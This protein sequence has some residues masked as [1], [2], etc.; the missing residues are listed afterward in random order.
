M[1]EGKDC[2]AIYIVFPFVAAIYGHL[3]RL[4]Q[5]ISLNID[6]LC[7]C[8]DLMLRVTQPGHR[9]KWTPSLQKEVR[10]FNSAVLNTY[11]PN[12]D[13]GI[14]TFKFQ[15]L[16]HLYDDVTR[17]QIAGHYRCI[18]F[19]AF[20][21]ATLFIHR[22]EPQ[23][24]YEWDGRNC[25]SHTWNHGRITIEQLL[26]QPV[27]SQGLQTGLDAD[28]ATHLCRDGVSVSPPELQLFALSPPCGLFKV[29]RSSREWPC[30]TSGRGVREAFVWDISARQRS[31]SYLI[32][33]PVVAT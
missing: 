9:E 5:G 10:S 29:L 18:S 24:L 8:T 4:C 3:Y 21:M 28:P 11:R 31:N 16:H 6:T 20:Y 1:L 22:R 14:F 7:A 26:E 2:R 32:I 30:D 17:F 33:D 12:C 23:T 13:K 15:F 19:L 27:V 25:S